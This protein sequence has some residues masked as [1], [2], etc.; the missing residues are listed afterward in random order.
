MKTAKKSDRNA[1]QNLICAVLLICGVVL[2]F[3]Y[4]YRSNVK[5]ITHQN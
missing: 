1:I 2:S 5:R 4:F 3:V